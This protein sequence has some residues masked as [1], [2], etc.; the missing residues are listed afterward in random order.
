[1]TRFFSSH[2]N[3][4]PCAAHR[5][6]HREGRSTSGGKWKNEVIATLKTVRDEVQ[7]ASR[8]TSPQNNQ[9][10]CQTCCCTKLRLRGCVGNCSP[11]PQHAFGWFR[12]PGDAKFCNKGLRRRTY[13]EGVTTSGPLFGGD[14]GGA[15]ASHARG[16]SASVQVATNTPK[17]RPKAP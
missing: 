13:R 6:P 1:M 14:Q 10:S 11:A 12:H 8:A 4:I 9:G 15:Q 2:F 7:G 3:E 17:S 5:P 16:M